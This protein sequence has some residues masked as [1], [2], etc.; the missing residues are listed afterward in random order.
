MTVDNADVDEPLPNLVQTRISVAPSWK[1][2][3]EKPV[4]AAEKLAKEVEDDR[5][6]ELARVA[7]VEKLSVVLQQIEKNRRAEAAFAAHNE[8]DEAEKAVRQQR[9]KAKA[10]A[11][12]ERASED[13]EEASDDIPLSRR[14][15][16]ASV[17]V[18]KP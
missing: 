18:R 10:N 12:S 16:K 13:D 3:A 4:E 15:T 14:R 7:E 8:L 11:D 1:V 9:A 6:A 17:A 2:L 5:L